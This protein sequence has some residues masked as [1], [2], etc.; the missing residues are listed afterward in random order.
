MNKPESKKNNY[1]TLV[2]LAVLLV[3]ILLIGRRQQNQLTPLSADGDST[4]ATQSTNGTHISPE[5][6]S[7]INDAQ[8][9][10]AIGPEHY[11]QPAPDILITDI[12]GSQYK[13]S[14]YKGAEVLVTLWATWCPPC[15]AEVEHLK[16][17]TDKYSDSE[18]KILAISTETEGEGTVK[19]FA[20]KKDVNYTMA[21]MEHHK[22]PAPYVNARALPS[23]F[24]IDKNGNFKLITQGMMDTESIEAVISLQ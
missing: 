1:F 6:M 15:N 20:E 24:F 14:D 13:I 8:S 11:G 17:L 7:I 9:W 22:L 21:W 12:Y 4:A 5:L 19:K 23:A 18:L 10:E 3:G 2:A 16:E